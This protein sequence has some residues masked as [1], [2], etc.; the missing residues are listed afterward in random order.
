VGEKTAS[1]LI[2]EYGSVEAVLASADRVRNEK[3]KKALKEHADLARL[4]KELATVKTDAEIEFTLEKARLREP[5]REKL[6]RIFTELEFSTLLQDLGAGQ[7]VLKG[8]YVLVT[9]E[10]VFSA[11]LKRLE[12]AGSFTLGRS[13]HPI[14]PQRHGLRASPSA[15]SPVRPVTSP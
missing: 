3:I 2:Q 8:R 9:T 14:P 6:R 15:W 5:D 13:P 12:E 7:K 4:S 10:E 1:K 11:F